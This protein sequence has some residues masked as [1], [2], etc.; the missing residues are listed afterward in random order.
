MQP[1][2]ILRS[3]AALLDVVVPWVLVAAATACVA[4]RLPTCSLRIQVA[5]QVPTAS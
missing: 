3:C 2:D 4:R 5:P 1:E